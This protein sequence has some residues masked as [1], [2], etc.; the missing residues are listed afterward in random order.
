MD[1]RPTMKWIIYACLFVIPFIVLYVSY[2]LFFPFISGKGFAFRILV[3]IA[4]SAWVVLALAEP[5]YRPKFS[6]TL[7]LYGALVVWM[8]L[9]DSFAVSPMKAF[10][11]NFERMDGWVTLIHMFAFFLVAG[12][13]LTADTLWRKW[14][15][16]FLSASAIVSLYGLFQ[17][18]GAF[19]IHQGGVRLDATLGNAAYLGG[20]LLF[21]IAVA[22]WLAVESKGWVRY[23]LYTLAGFHSLILFFTATR[24]AILGAIGAVMLGIFL[25]LFEAGKKGRVGGSIAIAVILLLVGSIFV[26]RHTSFI[27]HDPTLSR[28]AS[29]S[30]SDGQTRFAIWNMAWHGFEAHPMLGWGQE[31]FNYIFNT[32]YEPSMYAQEPWFDR[33][34]NAFLDWLTAGGAPAL[35][36]FVGLLISA[37]VAFYRKTV[38]QGERI[39]LTCVV[40]AYSFQALFIFDNLFSYIPI[41]AVLALAHSASA[42]PFKKLEHLP[43]V[44]RDI[45]GTVVTPVAIVGAVVVLWF[46]NVPNLSAGH[47]LLLA[48]SPQQSY[49]DNL[50]YFKT[51]I[52]DG[53]FAEQE[54]SEQIVNYV[55][56]VGAQTQITPE[57]KAPLYAYAI[58]QIKAEEAQRPLDARVYL[59]GSLVYRIAG[60]MQSA[61]KQT[62]AALALSPVKQ[63][64]LLEQGTIY[65]Q[66]GNIPKAHEIYQKAYALD[67]GFDDANIYAAAGEILFGNSAGAKK[68][69]LDHYATT[70][71]DNTILVYAYYQVKQY[72]DMILILEQSNRNTGSI[73]AGFHLASAYMLVGRTGDARAIIAKTVAAH[74]EAA[75]AGQQLLSQIK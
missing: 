28:L 52:A 66:L 37:V 15:M 21:A 16:T 34:H 14:W 25:W 18:L 26:F 38:S 30:L 20:Y 13:V 60:D 39:M 1:V 44:S 10:W 58:E 75:G 31:G 63:Q 53:S 19:Q 46:V 33:A 45:V 8:F 36:L 42:R 68:I 55:A 71:V 17:Y 23:T 70:T 27:E 51:A 67:H 41:A 11:S 64:I 7:A 65:W 2:S 43:A 12:S 49:A 74:P 9:A 29:V 62:E 5:K 57:Q 56:A 73:D 4:F 24:G 40:A 22:L 47:D 61:L 3:E 32:Y 48:L 50:A 35:L 6:W 54:I 59:Q 72:P 69:L